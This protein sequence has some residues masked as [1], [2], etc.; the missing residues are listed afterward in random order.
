MAQLDR[1]MLAGGGALNGA[2]FFSKNITPG[3]MAA[4]IGM[5]ELAFATIGAWGDLATT[6]LVFVTQPPGAVSANVAVVGARVTAVQTITLIFAN[7]T[8]AANVPTA[9][10]YGFL[11]IR[12]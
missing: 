11:V 7:L 1:V 5:Q 6:D 3:A 4:S 8:A 9:G 10:V 2:W 12:P